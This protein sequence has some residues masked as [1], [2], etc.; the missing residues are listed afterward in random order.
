MNCIK[1]PIQL[2]HELR[3]FF[4]RG[5]NATSSN[6]ARLTGIA[7][8]Q[9]YRNLYDRPKRV[10]R[11]LKDLCNYANISIFT[12]QLDPRTSPILMEALGTVWD[13]S[14]QHAK[15]LAELLFAHRKACL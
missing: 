15:R 7:Q 5:G 14:E 12:E 11:T 3:Q 1:T 8:S 9:V 10:S 6:I 4:E 13:G 2:Q